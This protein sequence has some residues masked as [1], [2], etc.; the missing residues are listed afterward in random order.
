M[1]FL[2]WQKEEVKLNVSESNNHN[3]NDNDNKYNRNRNRNRKSNHSHN[4]D[5][6]DNRTSSKPTRLRRKQGKPQTYQTLTLKHSKRR[7]ANLPDFDT[8]KDSKPNTE[9]TVLLPRWVAGCAK[10][11]NKFRDAEPA[12]TI[13][14]LL[15]T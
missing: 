6:N 10:P 8:N 9:T 14:E 11:N 12:S 5:N 7:R 3:D 13:S 2:T 4:N 15:K 1:L